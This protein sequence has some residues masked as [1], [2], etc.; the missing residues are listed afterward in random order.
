MRLV[1]GRMTAIVEK[2]VLAYRTR[3]MS[4]SVKNCVPPLI[5][6]RDKIKSEGVTTN[7]ESFWEVYRHLGLDLPGMTETELPVIDE[8]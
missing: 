4:E 5:T 8:A 1:A 2:L 7:Y 6:F 3:Q